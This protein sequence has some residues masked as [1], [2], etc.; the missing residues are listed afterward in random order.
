MIDKIKVVA[1]YHQPS[2]KSLDRMPQYIADELDGD[3]QYLSANPFKVW[4]VILSHASDI[5]VLVID[6][7]RSHTIGFANGIIGS[8]L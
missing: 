6:D 1:F 5:H 8:I 7:T 2:N 3:C 4:G